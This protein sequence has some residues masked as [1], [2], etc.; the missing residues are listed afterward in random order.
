M[1]DPYGEPCGCAGEVALEPHLLFQVRED[2]LDHQSCR[3]E[4]PLTTE[5]GC[6]ARLVRREQRRAGRGE[7]GGIVAAPEAFVADHDLA[8]CAGE[9]VGERFVLFLVS[10]HDRVAER[11]PAHV[12]QQHEPHSPDIAVVRL[13]VAVA[14]EA[15]ELAVLLTAGVAGDREQRAVAEPDTATVKPTREPL[16]YVAD[17]LDQAAQPAVVLRLVGQV[18]KPT[19]QHPADQAEELPVRADPDRGLRD[20]QRH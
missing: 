20:R 7:A 10:G 4:R 13:R 17:Q 19:R 12:G 3:G 15:R 11:Q 9:Q 5:V 6:G 14:G 18:R 2:A 16:L 1:G 8:R